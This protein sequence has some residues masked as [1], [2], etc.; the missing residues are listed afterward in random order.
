MQQE[1]ERPIVT[2]DA[3][4]LAL[5]EQQLH[6]LLARRPADSAFAPGQWALPGGFIHT[7]EDLTDEDAVKRVL[8]QKAGATARYIEQLKT[9]A[10][11]NRDSRGW[12]VSIAHLVLVDT[13]VEN[14]DQ[15][16]YFA[17]DELPDLPFDHNQI[18]R[19]AVE[20]V[21]NKSTYS[22][23]P[24]F[25]LPKVFTLPQMQEVYEIVLGQSLNTPAFRRKVFD[26]GLVEE[27]KAPAT[28]KPRQKG[29]PA[30]YYTLAQ[31]SLQHLGR[32][33][34]SPDERRG[35]AR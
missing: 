22:S 15:A 14:E 23:L 19:E 32:T 17:V 21:R 29:R 33:V 35:G 1:Y 28:D 8:A 11:A 18:I 26:Q 4:V 16:R 24:T 13:L 2:V 5:Q 25:F 30:Q 9:F 7:D 12:S 6:V 10:S 27:C 31:S 34:M 3:V 20:R